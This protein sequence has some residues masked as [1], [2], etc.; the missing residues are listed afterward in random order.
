MKRSKTRDV[1][2][3]KRRTGEYVFAKWFQ[4]SAFMELL[5]LALPTGYKYKGHA[6]WYNGGW[7]QGQEVWN[8]LDVKQILPQDVF[9]SLKVT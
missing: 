6:W 9:P 8:S 3:A 1:V 4:S 7:H 5:Q 2:A